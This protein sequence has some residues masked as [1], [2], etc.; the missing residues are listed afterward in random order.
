MRLRLHHQYWPHC[1]RLNAKPLSPPLPRRRTGDEPT[2]Q[3][4]PTHCLVNALTESRSYQVPRH[5]SDP[6]VSTSFDAPGTETSMF[7]P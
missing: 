3:R 2:L 7:L 6:I 4:E 1:T 5:P